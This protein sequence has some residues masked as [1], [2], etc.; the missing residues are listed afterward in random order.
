[1]SAGLPGGLG[2]AAL[3]ARRDFKQLEQDLPFDP[4]IATFQKMLEI[5]KLARLEGGGVHGEEVVEMVFDMELLETGQ[6]LP[7]AG[8][9]CPDRSRG[10]QPAVDL[11]RGRGI[12]PRF[13]RRGDIDDARRAGRRFSSTGP[14][15]VRRD[16]GGKQAGRW[17]ACRIRGGAEII[18][19]QPGRQC[20]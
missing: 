9:L 14:Q 10:L 7:Q 6:F 17:T 11:R 12:A 20:R 19:N 5:T 1:M 4:E 15:A 8:E 16:S 2:G 3:R 18:A 13:H